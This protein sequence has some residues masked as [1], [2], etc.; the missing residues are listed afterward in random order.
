[1]EVCAN[2]IINSNHKD[3][4]RKTNNDRRWCVMFCAQ[5][6]AEH[7]VRD[8]MDD[9]YFA[10]LYGWLNDGGYAAVSEYL[11]TYAIPAEFGLNCLLSRA[12]VTSSTEEA[13]AC[14][15]GRV[16]QEVQ[17]AIASGAQGF[18]N[19]WV[20]SLAL[21]KLL[22]EQRMEAAMPR[23]KRA[24]MLRALGYEHHP[25]LRGGR[26]TYAPPELGGRP[27]LF[28][29]R[30]SPM[31][32]LTKSAEIVAA[33]CKAQMVGAVEMMPVGSQEVAA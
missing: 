24:D 16:E 23:A 20:S 19:G 9:T 6:H 15:L 5:Q 14:G 25:A 1:M 18:A 21:D 8:G 32:E 10:R 3:A 11:H 4:I 31:R 12:P 13:V 30:G 7:L 33:Y 22:K 28:I 29:R 26:L 27:V 2:F 17:E